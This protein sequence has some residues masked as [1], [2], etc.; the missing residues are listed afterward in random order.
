MLFQDGR[1]LQSIIW[2]V[3]MLAHEAGILGLRLWTA[4]V[5]VQEPNRVCAVRLC[6]A[7]RH[8]S[9]GH[10]VWSGVEVQLAA[11]DKIFVDRL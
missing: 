1:A 7:A 10:H 2:P 3:Y 4:P 5:Q 9:C 11:V 8:M 6:P